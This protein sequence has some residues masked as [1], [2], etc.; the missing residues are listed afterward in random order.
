MKKLLSILLMFLSCAVVYSSEE[1]L[2]KQATAFY[3]DNNRVKTMDV[4]LL[5]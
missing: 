5:R 4:L 1:E 3:S 2:S